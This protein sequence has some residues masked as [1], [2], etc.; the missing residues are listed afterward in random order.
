MKLSEKAQQIQLSGTQAI[1]DRAAEMKRKGIDVVD[2]GAGDPQFAEPEAVR[3]GFAR[4]LKEG[5]THYTAT[6]G[7][8]ELEEALRRRYRDLYDLRGEAKVL[9]TS[10]AKAALYVACQVSFG[11]GDSVLLPSPCWVSYPA[12]LR[13]VGAEPLFVE[14][15]PEDDFLPA[16]AQLEEALTEETKGILINSPCNPT[17]GVY[18]EEE[19]REIA[20]L[21]RKEDLLLI[22]DE[23]YE[24]YTYEGRHWSFAQAEGGD[25]LIV[26]SASKSF[27]MTGWRIGYL[28]GPA[29]YVEKAAAFQGHF[30]SAPCS[31]AQYAAAEAFRAQ[32]RFPRDLREKFRQRRDY[33]RGALNGLPGFDCPRP[34]GSFYLFPSV[35]GLIERLRPAVTDDAELAR[36]LL[37]EARVVVVPGSSFGAPDHL[38]FAYVR[39]LE[40]LKE[41]VGR[42]EEALRADL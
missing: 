3:R 17:G 8:A 2:L 30:T 12:Q 37:E 1:N 15:K 25:V 16:P 29:R 10:G 18:R 20:R 34:P 13:L 7:I 38:R 6:A 26:G 5:C 21:A 31:L 32:P 9:V 27:A 28:I 14:G 33:L 22:S 41:A 11:E 19:G 24:G 23:C 39:S 42:M 4:A 40:R 35:K 36:F